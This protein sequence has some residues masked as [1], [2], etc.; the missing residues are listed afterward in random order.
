VNETGREFLDT[1]LKILFS[2][3]S[4]TNALLEKN[5]GKFIS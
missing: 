5:P 4:K 1:K 2:P 3:G